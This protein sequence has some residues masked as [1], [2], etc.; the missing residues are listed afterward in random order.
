MSDSRTPVSRQQR[1]AQERARRKS[2][3][4]GAAL[5]L[6]AAAL[7]AVP[8]AQAATFTV[9]SL[10]DSGPGSL[11]QAIQEPNR[12]GGRRTPSNFQAGPGRAPIVLDNGPA[13]HHPIW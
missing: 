9:S 12:L 10:G 5:T 4:N 13:R 1:R 8:S 11:R 3:K 2:R 7:A 6:G